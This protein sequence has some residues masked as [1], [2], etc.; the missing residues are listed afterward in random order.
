[1]SSPKSKLQLRYMLKT[2]MK[3]VWKHQ[4]AWPFHVPVDAV[5]LKIPDYHEIIKNPMDLGTIKKKLENSE[6]TNVS[7]CT[8]DFL[9]MFNN[10][11]LYNK[12]EED[13]SLM[14]RELQ[15]YTEEQ[16]NFLPKY[17]EFD[18]SSQNEKSVDSDIDD[19]HETPKKKKIKVDNKP[20][21]SNSKFSNKKKK[22]S[23]AQKTIKVVGNSQDIY[24]T[25]NINEAPNSARRES[26]H[27]YI[28][29]TIKNFPEDDEKWYKTDSQL[30]FCW[31][32]VNELLSKKYHSIAWPFYTPV[33]VV[34]LGLSDYYDVIKY[35]MDLGTVKSKLETNQYSNSNEFA[36][37]VR[38]IFTNC[39]RYNSSEHDVVNM[40][41]KLQEVF[42]LS[43]AKIPEISLPLPYTKPDVNK[44][45]IES[46][47]SPNSDSASVDRLKQ[48]EA[49]LYLVHKQLAELK[50]DKDF[51]RSD[52]TTHTPKSKPVSS[53]RPSFDQRSQLDASYNSTKASVSSTKVLTEMDLENCKP[54]TYDEKRQLSI[55]INKLPG[56][57]LGDIVHIIQTRESDVTGEGSEEIEIDFEKLKP[58]TLRELERFVAHCMRKKSS[59]L[60]KKIK[61]N[62]NVDVRK[63]ESI[64]ETVDEIGFGSKSR[65]SDT[66]S[67]SDS[68][69]IEM[70][71][72]SNAHSASKVSSNNSASLHK[73]SI[74]NGSSIINLGNQ[75]SSNVSDKH[76][77]SI[78]GD[79]LATNK[80]N[81][82]TFGIVDESLLP[83][84]MQILKDDPKKIPDNV[85]TKGS[86]QATSS[87]K[88]TQI[89]D[90]NKTSEN[91]PTNIVTSALNTELY[92]NNPTLS[93]S[94]NTSQISSKNDIERLKEE[95]QRKR[96]ALAG[97]LNLNA[98]FDLL[99]SFEKNL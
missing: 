42:E 15:K 59:K 98:Q 45:S 47:N 25:K 69:D 22:S 55:D 34:A 31:N 35:P 53:A 21:K 52:S 38:L 5:K 65:L 48:L 76:K 60:K 95:E 33:D 36:A 71:P 39:Y 70:N 64:K 32:L 18:G 28:K 3:N 27:R 66:S 93:S 2:V 6:Y 80:D 86:T 37:D 16:I 77:S 17:D 7:Q 4:Y 62:H 90:D 88:S 61:T 29:K 57:K 49:Q 99:T 8:D 78:N 58:S 87:M 50:G 68:S 67:S 73:P 13:I 51:T 30:Q 41:K 19:D 63:D 79:K 91:L 12:P 40:A 24:P 44:N 92:R 84:C 97:T 20:N 23:S 26:S 85:F 14:C 74:M 9:L 46:V 96:M 83:S 56:E 11:L 10:C 54:M 75:K 94:P 43:F 81:R 89:L 1:M 82:I 72:S